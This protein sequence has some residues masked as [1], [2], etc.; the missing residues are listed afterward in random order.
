MKVD[1]SLVKQR[2]HNDWLFLSKKFDERDVKYK[3]STFVKK[4][5]TWYY[6]KLNFLVDVDCMVLIEQIQ[7][8]INTHL[9]II[10]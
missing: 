4:H 7:Y 1:L 5:E 3:Q 10:S 6:S 2:G 8:F 9:D